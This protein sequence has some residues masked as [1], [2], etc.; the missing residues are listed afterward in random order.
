MIRNTS[1]RA[2]GNR[3]G[4]EGTRKKKTLAANYWLAPFIH[5][6]VNLA[7]IKVKYEISRSSTE[8]RAANVSIT[9]EPCVFLEEIRSPPS[10]P[11][12]PPANWNAWPVR[13]QEKKR[14]KTVSKLEGGNDS[15]GASLMARN[16]T[17]AFHEFFQR[18]PHVW[19]TNFTRASPRENDHGFSDEERQRLIA[20]FM[21]LSRQRKSDRGEISRFARPASKF[22]SPGSNLNLR[23]DMRYS[24][25][26][27]RCCWNWERSFFEKEL[28]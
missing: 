3:R 27:G 5:A 7:G 17:R 24:V 25:N 8:S 10:P 13:E 18:S 23:V 26:Y 28:L 15:R 2:R 12:F 4:S 21:N 19:D 16:S 11:R 1:A 20:C 9:E 6:V 22:I 14:R